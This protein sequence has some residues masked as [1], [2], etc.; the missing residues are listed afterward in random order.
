VAAD[1]A[2]AMQLAGLQACVASGGTGGLVR[3]PRPSGRQAYVVL[4]SQLP[5]GEDLFPNSRGGVLF[6]MHDPARRKAPTEW[7]IAELLHISIGA[8]KVVQALLEGENLKDHAGRVG[9]SMNTVRFHLKNA[10]AGTDT[11]SQAEL[12]RIAMS[13]LIALEPHFV[14]STSAT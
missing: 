12:V 11:H 13:D 4:V 9:I 2:A 7:R 6:A 5:S 10:F 8:A 14:E 3:V 1:R